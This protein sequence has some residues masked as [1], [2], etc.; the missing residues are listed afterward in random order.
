MKLLMAK[1]FFTLFG[2]LIAVPFYLSII[3]FGGLWQLAKGLRKE[4]G[5]FLAGIGE[6]VKDIWRS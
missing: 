6:E 3:I 5:E 4:I 1:I 2:I